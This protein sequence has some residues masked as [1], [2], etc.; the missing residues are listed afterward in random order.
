MLEGLHALKHA[1]RFG[2]NVVEIVT[3]D[4]AELARLA[5]ELAPDLSDTLRE[6]ARE[7]EPAVFGRLAPLPPATGVIA[8]AERPALDGRGGARRAEPRAD[9]AAR[10][11]PRPRQHGRMRTRG[12]R[13]G[14]RRS[15]HAPAATTPGTPTR[16]AAPPGLHFAVPVARLEQLGLDELPL[17]GRCD[18]PLLAID[19]DGEPL[20]P[21]ALPAR[22]L[23]AFGTERHGLSHDSPRAPTPA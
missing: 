7:V 13:R 23:L 15:A 18:R 14:R 8:L 21:A 4:G 20:D 1:L 5:G 17:R 9:R 12:R 10:G 3:R 2:A 16:C 6:R 19:P 22:A 11:P